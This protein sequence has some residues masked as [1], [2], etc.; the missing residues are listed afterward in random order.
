MVKNTLLI[1]EKFYKIS[2]LEMPRILEFEKE[3]G[4][5]TY[6]CVVKKK[7]KKIYDY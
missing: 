3:Y 2:N 4:V 5:N 6:H 1:N 7:L